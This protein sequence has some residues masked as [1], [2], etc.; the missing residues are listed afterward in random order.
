MGFVKG[1]LAPP[2]KRYT[3]S[4]N[5]AHESAGFTLIELMA[6]LGILGLIAIIAVPAIGSIMGDASS[7]ADSASVDLA[8][9][10]ART[11]DVSGLAH[12][13]ETGYSVGA[14]VDAGYLDVPADAP[15]DNDTARIDRIGG[16][17]H[18]FSDAGIG[19]ENI[20]LGTGKLHTMAGPHDVSFEYLSE[21]MGQENVVK[22]TN[23][24]SY[25]T[26]ASEE[27]YAAQYVTGEAYT[28]SVSA[29][30]AGDKPDRQPTV[31]V[32]GSS[33]GYRA[34]EGDFSSTGFT[35]LHRTFTPSAASRQ[36]LHFNFSGYDTV[37]LAMN[38]QIEKGDTPTPYRL[39][40]ADMPQ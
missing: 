16:A 9:D 17:Y 20:L 35:R 24:S 3:Y 33:G 22:I 30:Y 26:F 8:E 36:R 1:G 23:P 15:L 6:V 2:V 29:M 10:A 37:Y 40:P 25:V 13:T 4:K 28:I 31:Y 34:L 39:A 5:N 11:A 12:D 38:I 21:Y 18:Y 14:L 27:Q 7:G 32:S 19:G